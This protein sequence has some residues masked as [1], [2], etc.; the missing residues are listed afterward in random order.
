MHGTTDHPGMPADD[1][2]GP[3]GE[4]NLRLSPEAVQVVSRLLADTGDSPAELFRKAVGLYRLS[5]DA[6]RE[7]KAV[8]A[9]GS[10]EVL[11]TEFVGF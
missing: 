3:S 2:P 5:V 11:E 8:G 9:A 1:R 6:H 7:G 4:L 10:A